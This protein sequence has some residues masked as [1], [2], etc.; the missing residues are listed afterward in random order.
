M[1]TIDLA[2]STVIFA[3][4]PCAEDG[5]A[6]VWL[7]LVRR[8][9]DPF[10]ERWALPGGVADAVE[11]LSATAA[12]KLFETTA[13]EPAYLEQLYAFGEPD[14]SPTG[15]VVS[16]VYWALVR[17]EQAEAATVDEN[18]RWFEADA[19]PPLAF[20]HNLIVEYA[21]WR[22]RTKMEYSR[23]AHAFL[24][25]TFTLSELRQVHEAVLGKPL[26]P[27]N[28]RRQVESSPAIVR[29]EQHVTGGRHRPPRLYRY[30]ADI[31][32]VDNGP[33]IASP[34]PAGR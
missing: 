1:S 34:A 30:D 20:D 14:R 26:D 19:L 3:L 24:G 17:T 18:V 28:F 31:E 27:A 10:A 15:R 9:R 12:R 11:S 33:L 21:L 6:T 13:L 8:T 16:I 22:L 7:P 32:L 23:I 5:R 2:V 29:T 25:E 4:R